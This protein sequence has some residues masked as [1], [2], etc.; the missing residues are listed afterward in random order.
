[1]D[2][3]RE[4][5][6]RIEGDPMLDGAHSSY[7]PEASDFPGHSADEIAYHINLLLEEGFLK[8]PEPTFQTSALAV[9]RLTSAGHNFLDN[10]RNQDIWS[11]TKAKFKGLGGVGLTVIAAIA[12]AE[13]KKHLGLS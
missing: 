3:V 12:E 4:V 13:V 1:M 2:L 5:L 8:A 11:K 6:L 9:A 7:A 10:I